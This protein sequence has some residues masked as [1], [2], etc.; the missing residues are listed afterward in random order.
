MNA[1]TKINND[2]RQALINGVDNIR[3]GMLGVEGSEHPMHPMTHYADWTNDRLWFLTS[4]STTLVRELIPRARANFCVMDQKAGFDACL[5]GMLSQDLN[6]EYLDALWSP[7]AAAWF[8]GGKSDPDLTMLR[9]DLTEA[10]L[11]CSSTG[12]LNYGFEILKA[13]LSADTTPDLGVHHVLQ[14]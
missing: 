8:K 9:F 3:A 14:F 5:I 6:R 12:V 11:W 13:N 7:L 4:R 2:P 10:A 1:F